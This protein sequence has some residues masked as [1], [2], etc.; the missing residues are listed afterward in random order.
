MSLRS[1]ARV[2][3]NESV[4]QAVMVMI[5]WGWFIV[6]TSPS[7]PLLLYASYK[8]FVAL[9]GTDYWTVRSL[10]MAVLATTCLAKVPHWLKGIMV[11]AQFIWVGFITSR[12]WMIHPW[13]VAPYTYTAI[14]VLC[15]WLLVRSLDAEQ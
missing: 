4:P 15:L 6:I 14:T 1:L 13:N 7:K 9:G 11:M 10:I 3:K 2:M 5:H 12:F 8:P